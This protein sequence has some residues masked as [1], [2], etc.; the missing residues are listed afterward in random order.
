[1]VGVVVFLCLAAARVSAINGTGVGDRGDGAIE[2]LLI[3]SLDLVGQN[4]LDD[5]WNSI[6]TLLTLRPDFRLA[7]AILGDLLMARAGGI[8]RFGEGVVGHEKELGD[9]LS[10]AKVRLDN[11]KQPPESALP[12]ELLR[13]PARYDHVV[14]VDLSRSR[15]YIFRNWQSI[16]EKVSDYYIAIGKAG[17]G[18]EHQ[19]DNRTPVGFYHVT[20]YLASKTLPPFYGAGAFPLDYPN[21]WDRLHRRTGGGIWLH[22][23][24]ADTYSR[25]PRA[26]EGCVVLTNPD[27]KSLEHYLT[28]DNP[29]ILAQHIE[30]LPPSEW[31]RRRELMIQRVYQWRDDWLRFKGEGILRYYSSQYQ[32]GRM[33]DAAWNRLLDGNVNLMD[34]GLMGYPGVDSMVVVT[35]GGWQTSG[36]GGRGVPMTQYWRREE[37]SEWKI[38]FEPNG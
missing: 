10:E 12:G 6:Q 34:P 14:M 20:G 36:T 13:I 8:T 37:G 17:A 27:F 5:A 28:V 16:P 18:K 1:M 25:P 11:E 22:G 35:W 24:P 30:W 2:R 4:R 32:S 19:G 29:V 3:Q 31:W 15:L 26:S 38:V 7:N 21:A 9:L 23:S 33:D